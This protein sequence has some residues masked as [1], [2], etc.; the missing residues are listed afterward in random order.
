MGI[1]LMLYRSRIGCHAARGPFRTKFSPPNALDGV[2]LCA[3]LCIAAVTIGLAAGMVVQLAA[4][5]E[6]VQSMSAALSGQHMFDVLLLADFNGVNAELARRRG[7]MALLHTGLEY[8]LAKEKNLQDLSFLLLLSGSVER[9]PGPDNIVKKDLDE[10]IAAMREDNE[11]RT[12][13][14]EGRIMEELR[15]IG[16]QMK[17]VQTKVDDIQKELSELK[18]K[19]IEQEECLEGISNR[20]EDIEE[21]LDDMEDQLERQ[22]QDRRRDNI[23]LFNIAE[24]TRESN[25]EEVFLDCV[26][27]VLPTQLTKADV[28]RTH[29]IG[30]QEPDKHRP[31][32]AVLNRTSDKV[33][34]LQARDKLRQRGIGVSSDKTPLQRQRLQEAREDGKFAFYKGSKLHVTSRPAQRDRVQT[35][36]ATASQRGGRTTT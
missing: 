25:N 34:I 22:E 10:A 33:A 31:L 35:R 32:L 19:I 27:S 16:G 26:N 11:R 9:K 12:R 17:Q 15:R 18:K 23:I 20:Q 1:T 28:R 2:S 8:P 14:S 7:S 4:S 24:D 5:L 3:G 36:S 6:C 21:R 30:R 13:E 29:R